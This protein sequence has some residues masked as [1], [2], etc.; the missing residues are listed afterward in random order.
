MIFIRFYGV[1]DLEENKLIIRSEIT[2][3]TSCACP[4][5]VEPENVDTTF[6]LLFPEQLFIRLAAD[7]QH[8]QH[9]V[10]PHTKLHNHARPGV[11]APC[12][13]RHEE[14]RSATQQAESSIAGCLGQDDVEGENVNQVGL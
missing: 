13:A 12:S 4:D 3:L 9:A 6:M 11:M 7:E 14:A 5:F 1:V 10:P 2:G 8:A